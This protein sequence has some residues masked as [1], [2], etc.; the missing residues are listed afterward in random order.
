M[1]MFVESEMRRDIWIL[2]NDINGHNPSSQVSGMQ[3]YW[4]YGSAISS[5]STCL[6]TSLIE[7]GWVSRCSE[8]SFL[9][10]R[11]PWI[12][13]LSASFFPKPTLRLKPTCLVIT[14]VKCL[15]SCMLGKDE[16]IEVGSISL[17]SSTLKL[18]WTP[19][20]P[21]SGLCSKYKASQCD[22][23]N[24]PISSPTDHVLRIQGWKGEFDNPKTTNQQWYN[25]RIMI[26]GASSP[27]GSTHFTC[28]WWGRILD[29]R[30]PSS[31]ADR[32]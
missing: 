2:H 11:S 28:S 4:T 17:L 15:R 24:K 8:S 3:W 20:R 25:S 32:Y 16:R 30:L 26:S 29:H 22:R 13:I 12:S 23:A 6:R 5:P 14:W 9:V 27:T 7:S 1:V 19:S 18:P 21:L 31:L 10:R